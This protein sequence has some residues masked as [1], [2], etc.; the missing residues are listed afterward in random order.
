ML[1]CWIRGEAQE[2]NII[3]ASNLFVGLANEV[4][5]HSRNASNVI[6]EVIAAC[7]FLV[8]FFF[9]LLK[10]VRRKCWLTFIR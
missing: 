7:L 4:T 1:P 2:I 8:A 5:V 9:K 10:V 6:Y 3:N